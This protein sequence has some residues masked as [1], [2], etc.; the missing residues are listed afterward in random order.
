MPNRQ[1]CRR[2]GVCTGYGIDPTHA[3]T[4]GDPI[5]QHGGRRLRGLRAPPRSKELKQTCR[6]RS[7]YHAQICAARFARLATEFEIRDWNRPRKKFDVSYTH[8][9]ANHLYF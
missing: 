2:A 8:L 3:D 4:F 6:A 5:D 1:P 7:A 9:A